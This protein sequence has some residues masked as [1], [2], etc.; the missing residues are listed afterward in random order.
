MKSITI[1]LDSRGFTLIEMLAAMAVFMVVIIAVVSLFSESFMI[2]FSGSHHIRMQQ[3]ADW[4]LA[5]MAARIRQGRKLTFPNSGKLGVIE[6]E[7]TSI[8]SSYYYQDGNKLTYIDRGTTRTLLPNSKFYYVS[9]LTFTPIYSN[10][11]VQIGLK[12]IQ[13]TKLSNTEVLSASSAA[14]VRFKKLY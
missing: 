9:N 3:D 5:T 1:K 6:A 14:A 11:G 4:A 10:R 13:P 12:L 2:F 7:G 8:Y